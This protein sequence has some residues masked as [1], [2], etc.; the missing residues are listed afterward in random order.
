[1]SLNCGAEKK[2]EKHFIFGIIA[3]KPGLL[4]RELFLMDKLHNTF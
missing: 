3:C 4:Q 2:F 1:M